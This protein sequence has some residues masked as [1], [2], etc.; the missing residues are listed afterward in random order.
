MDSIT[1]DLVRELAGITEALTRGAVAL[2]RIADACEQSSLDER[3]QCDECL[4]AFD[5]ANLYPTQWDTLLCVTCWNDVT[6]GA[7]LPAQIGVVK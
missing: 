6:N 2:E 4:A 5:R 3:A 1:R 7:P